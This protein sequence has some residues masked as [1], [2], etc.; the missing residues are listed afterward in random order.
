MST[1]ADIT[2]LRQHDMHDLAFLDITIGAV[3]QALLH[4]A[5]CKLCS[6][7]RR[8]ASAAAFDTGVCTL[9]RQ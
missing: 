4:L 2:V 3:V 9:C 5:A 7:C 6:R 8:I 1:S